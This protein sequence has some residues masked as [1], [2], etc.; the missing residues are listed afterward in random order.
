M[1]IHYSG[2]LRKSE[3]SMP[4][5]A[6]KTPAFRKMPGMRHGRPFM[7]GPSNFSHCGQKG[8]TPRI[9]ARLFPL[10][11]GSSFRPGSPRFG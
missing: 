7:D 2:T 1:I 9:A 4:A 11:R 8:R 5:A 10:L 6:D 3:L